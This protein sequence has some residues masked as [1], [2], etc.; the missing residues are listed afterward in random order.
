VVSGDGYVLGI[1]SEADVLRKQERAFGR[2]VMGLPLR[3][4]R[5]RAQ[6]RARSAS[7]LMTSPVITVRPDAPLGSAARLMNGRRIRRLPVVD[8]SG[9][10]IGIVSRRDLL[11]VFLRPDEEIAAEVH[12]VLTGVLLEE[13][14]GMTV[15]VRN[16]VVILSGTVARQELVPVAER[17]ASEV[18]GVVAVTSRFT[19]RS[20]SDPA[21]ASSQH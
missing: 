10:L 19:A 8:D 9:K 7:G 20:G 5:E 21:Q 4:R 16:G 14:D 15:T 18:A 11:S 3:T 13:P 12:A 2:L 6:A 1:V 17:L